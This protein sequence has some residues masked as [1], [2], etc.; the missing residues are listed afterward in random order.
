[1][2]G[3][4]ETTDSPEN[5]SAQESRFSVPDWARSG[6]GPRGRIGWRFLLSRR[7]L[8]WILAPVVVLIAVWTNYPFV[9]NLWV[10]LLSQPGGA[11]SSVS[12]PGQWAMR[13]GNPQG[14][15]FS[16]SSAIPQGVIERVIEVDPGV[17]SSPVI[18]GG[19]VYI[20]GQS[21]VLAFD[22]D[23]GERIWERPFSGPAHGVP[24]LAE[25]T[26][27][28]GTLNKRVIAL[29][30]RTGRQEW[31]YVGDSPFPGTVA[32]LDGV[33]YAGSRGGDVHAIDAES[34][35]RL[36]TVGL[37]SAAVAPVAVNDGKIFAASNGG[38][39]F[40][41]HSGTGDKRARI[42]TNSV[43]V[44][45]PTVGDGRVYLLLDGGLLAFDSGIREMPGRYPAELIWA[46]LWVWGFP[47]PSPAGY[48]GLLWRLQP[49]PD[50]GSFLHTPA[51]TR[52]AMFLGTDAGRVVALDPRDG[53][54]LWQVPL[55]A[56]VAA[57][58]LVVGDAVIVA[59]DDGAL[60]A[61]SR[62]SRE[63]LWKVSLDSPV[64]GSLAYAEGRIFAQ[65]ESGNLHVIR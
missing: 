37:D 1:M 23:S 35:Q 57:P 4:P 54:V 40:I 16:T 26:L 56:S 14:T 43:I 61:L 47:I 53:S 25:G 29:D 64:S 28:L 21:R 46:Q 33:V 36:W 32:V 45:P 27:Y 65:T 38:V 8:L 13:G 63:V 55:G 19:I 58:P 22:T 34:G 20:G 30:A 50:M 60:Q 48:S 31:E 5:T 59:Q 9:P 12:G 52:E 42:R 18:G 7:R 15:N 11:A 10:L 6:Q 3:G 62:S 39:L 24:A 44:K 49:G 51:S 41:R 2:A 17:R